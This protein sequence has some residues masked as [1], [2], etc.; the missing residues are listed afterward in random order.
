[1]FSTENVLQVKIKKQVYF[2]GFYV[3]FQQRAVPSVCKANR[4]RFRSCGDNRFLI[5]QQY[6]DDAIRFLGV[7]ASRRVT[8]TSSR[9]VTSVFRMDECAP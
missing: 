2:M 3:S 9:R 5:A 8:L 4:K 7:R 1:M 6:L